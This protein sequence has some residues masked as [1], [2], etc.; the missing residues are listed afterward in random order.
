MNISTG[1][2]L[3]IVAVFLGSAA[4]SFF[5]YRIVQNTILA[6][7]NRVEP[8]QD[9]IIFN[10]Q[11]SDMSGGGGM[12]NN[13]SM[14]TS[15]N[16]MTNV[17]STPQTVK[18]DMTV[19][20]EPAKVAVD[21]TNIPVIVSAKVQALQSKNY[22]KV[23]RVCVVVAN[24][25]SGDT[26]EYR[27]YAMD[28][29]ET[30]LYTSTNGTFNDVLPVD[31]GEYLLRV[32]NTRTNDSAEKVV[33]GFN[34]IGKWGVSKLE[35]QLN[36]P[37]TGKPQDKMLYFHFDIDKLVIEWAGDDAASAPTDLDALMAAAPAN[38]WTY[39]VVGTPKYDKYNRIVSFKV[40]PM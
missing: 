27:L 18:P 24:I 7:A 6:S 19:E 2:I 35:E 37:M 23:G 29:T 13:I 16:V 34:K 32:V 20:P 9:V 14:P 21:T 12:Q 39:Q 26:P 15:T 8:S 31:G 11:H 40:K 3:G 30:P 5:S 33:S 1:K 28:N 25:P 4:L 17:E 22:K 36:A 10:D 38:G